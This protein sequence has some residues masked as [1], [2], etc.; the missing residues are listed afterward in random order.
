MLVVFAR[1]NIGFLSVE[2]FPGY[3]LRSLKVQKQP[4]EYALQN[5][6]SLKFRKIHRKAPVLWN[7][8]E[9]LL[10]KVAMRVTKKIILVKKN[11]KGNIFF[12]QSYLHSIV[13]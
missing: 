1:L 4:F 7:I 8:C 13:C 10:L 9:R 3:R 12:R 2:K 5:R 11:K 6:C